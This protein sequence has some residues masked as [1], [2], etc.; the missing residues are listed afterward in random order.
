MGLLDYLFY[1]SEIL[2]AVSGVVYIK[3]LKAKASRYFVFF[4]CVTVLVETFGMLSMSFDEWYF[5]DSYRDSRFISNNYW[6]YNFYYLFNY[7]VYALFFRTYLIDHKKRNYLGLLVLIYLVT[8]FINLMF[9]G[10]L[11]ESYSSFNTIFGTFLILISVFLYFYEMLKSDKILK[12]YKNIEFYVA[13][14][15]LIF[16][17]CTTPLFIYSKYFK[18]ENDDFL[19]VY[20]F[21]LPLAIIFMYSCYTIGFIVCLK[22][23]KYF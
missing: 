6:L 2:A 7:A 23:N 9:S 1:F 3:Y 4:L 19:S 14:G 11:F 12:F 8:S 22:K 15:A 18:E 17:L 5:L 13:T 20:Y 10:V 21:V 16:H